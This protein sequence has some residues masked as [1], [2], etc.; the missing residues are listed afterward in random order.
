[1]S[2][3]M[4]TWYIYV[5]NFKTWMV[6]PV[7]VIPSI[8]FPAFFYILFSAP[9]SGVTNLPGFPTDDY[10]AYM[11]ATI[12]VMS[13]VFSGADS[14]MAILAD[15]LSGY[16]DKL[17]LA[18]INRFAMLLSSLL[19]AGTW[20]LFQVLVIIVIALIFGVDFQGGVAGIFFIILLATLL[21]M[22][23]SCVG[24]MIA[25]KS[26]SAQITQTSWLLFMPVA[27]LTTAYIPKDLLSGWFKWAV[28]INPVDYILDGIRAVIITGWEWGP[29]M[30]GIWVLVGMMGILVTAATWLYRRETA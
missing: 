10:E 4:Q 13:V 27:F 11:T 5:R 6:Q 23:W 30:L 3:L 2:I 20:A 16:F 26:K 21:G 28:T 1:M 19:M 12:L 7:L 29:I 9:L 18:P 24:L 14:A 25:I 17:L 22:A 15:I 8:I